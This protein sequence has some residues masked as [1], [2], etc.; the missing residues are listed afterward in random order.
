[1]FKFIL[2]ELFGDLASK[3]VTGAANEEMTRERARRVAERA[4]IR[5]GKFR[6]ERRG[7]VC[8]GFVQARRRE[9][10]TNLETLQI[11]K[12]LNLPDHRNHCLAANSPV[13]YVK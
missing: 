7:L 3:S 11:R 9:R 5:R 8:G 10:N 4:I 2:L 12:F 13:P 6:T 1:V